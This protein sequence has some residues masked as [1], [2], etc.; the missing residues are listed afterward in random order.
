MNRLGEELSPYLH[1]HR[2]NPV[3]W[4][5]W[6][7]E[8]FDR[9]RAEDKPVLLSVGYSTCHWCHV[10][11]SE[12]F[13]DDATA[14]LMNRLFVNIKVD[15][16]ERPDID[17]IYMEAVTTMAGRGGWPMTVFLTP[18]AK[19]FFAGTYFPKEP[20]GG[21][22]SFTDVLRQ[23]DQ[24]WRRRRPQVLTQAGD[25][26]ASVQRAV[27]AAPSEN[28]D[29][30][31]L[32]GATARLL[33][34]F[35]PADGG[36][37]GAPKFPHPMA[38]DALLRSYHRTND[39]AVLGAVTTSLDAMAAGG[40]YDQLGGGFA[41]YAV[42]AAWLIPHFEKML[43]DN[44]L[45][46]R[47]YLHAWQL[48]GTDGYRQILEETIAYVLGNLGHPDGGFYAAQSADSEGEEGRFYLWDPAQIDRALGSSADEFKTW[49]GVREEGNF[50]G[51][52]VLFRP[53]RG[54]QVRPPSVERGR[55]LLL[56]VRDGRARP[57]LDDKILTEW[58]G[59]MMATLAEAA[60]ATG[61]GQWL[62]AATAAGEFL[63]AN[64]RRD[65]GRWLRAWHA[66]DEQRPA[67]AAHLAYVAD[68]AALIDGFVRLAEA[69]GA[70]RWIAE[71][72]GVADAILDLFWDE[73]AGGVFTTGH[74]ADALVVRPKDVIDRAVPS[75][76]SATAVALLRLAA[77]VGERRYAEAGQ[78]IIRFAGRDS[79]TQ[80]LAYATLLAAADLQS[81][82]ATEIAIVGDR[83][84]LVRAAQQQ[85]L[86]NAVLAWGEPYDSPLWR[87][88]TEGN[89]YVCRDFACQLPVAD[90]DSLL[91]Q[92]A[93][94]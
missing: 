54:A 14:A 12:S 33:E 71:A 53:E 19:P 21:M 67:R 57:G 41:R 77:L 62:D 94:G 60:A 29:V 37:G 17:A 15:R 70:A 91:A 11:A 80:P 20:R 58:N 44:A 34:L 31:L 16:E 85:Y 56:A 4:L 47:V 6:G 84:D 39:L 22:P 24:A 78:E 2:D 76:N 74:D 55:T 42:D 69:S 51:R 35:D 93:A 27:V 38:L 36:F 89:A 50:E 48:T 87:D 10:M 5:P 88:R 43:S 28:T 30:D 3:D 52:S 18:D 40:I 75:G 46:A 32:P 68:H 7:D 90:A 64:L 81:T 13:E 25:L 82:G 26:T 45:L 65:D 72:C 86:P 63:L 66:G 59:L 49:Y 92:L 23:V 73:R 61:S 79:E 8:A 9:A 83:P 1:Q